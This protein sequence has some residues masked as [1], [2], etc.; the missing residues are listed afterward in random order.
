MQTQPDPNLNTGIE[1][2]MQERDCGPVAESAGETAQAV[3]TALRLEVR[4]ERSRNVREKA[5]GG[6]PLFVP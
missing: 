2:P 3:L 4:A 1:N 6:M 5:D